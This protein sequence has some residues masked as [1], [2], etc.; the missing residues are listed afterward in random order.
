[1]LAESVEGVLEDDADG[2]VLLLKIYKVL[3][4][5]LPVVQPFLHLSDEVQ[6]AFGLEFIEFRHLN[7]LLLHFIHSRMQE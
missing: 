2:H 3:L 6:D 7:I 1:M 5:Q 4:L